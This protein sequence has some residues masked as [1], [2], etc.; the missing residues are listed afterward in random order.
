MQSPP[1]VGIL[2]GGQLGRMLVESAN[3]LNM[4]VSILDVPNSPAKQIAAHDRHVVGSFADQKAVLELVSKCD[5]LTAEI[6]HIDTHALEIAEKAQAGKGRKVA[7]EPNW[8][9]IRVIQ[10]KLEQHEHLLKADVPVA[11]F[12]AVKKHVE[13]L[14][15]V[16]ERFGYPFMLKSRTHSYD[17]RGVLFELMR[18]F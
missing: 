6:E 2:G 14:E 15:A 18:S 9:S 7:I 1:T 11:E 4:P 12:V 16:G 3:R 5:V 17:G 10:D 13:D 8:R